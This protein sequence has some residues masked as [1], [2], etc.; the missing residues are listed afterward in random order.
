MAIKELSTRQAEVARLV[1]QGFT[2]K[3][4]AKKLC[5]SRRRVGETIFLIK[6]KWG[7]RSRVEIGILVYRFGLIDWEE[8][9]DNDQTGFKRGISIG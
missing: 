6:E 9:N 8:D 3:D 2:D 7:I 4:I 1:A 5:I